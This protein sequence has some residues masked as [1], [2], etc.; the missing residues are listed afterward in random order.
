MRFFQNG[1]QSVH[2]HDIT[3]SFGLI[4]VLDKS[5]IQDSD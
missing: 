5:L 4:A 3:S 2:E 1:K